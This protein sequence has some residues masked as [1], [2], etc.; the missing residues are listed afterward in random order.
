M[1]EIESYIYKQLAEKKISKAD[2]KKMLLEIKKSDKKVYKD[3]AII[4]VACKLPKAEN[5]KMF[6]NSLVKEKNC[7]DVF[8]KER[9][10]QWIEASLN[11]TLSEL[12]TGTAIP[13]GTTEKDVMDSR[14]VGGFLDDISSF[15]NGFFGISPKE[16]KFMNPEQR[17][18][19]ETAWEAV[20]DA[21][22]GGDKFYGTRTGVFIGKD[23]TNLGLYKYLTEADTMHVTG[24]W[25]G[26]LASRISYLYNLKGPSLVIDTACSSGLVSLHSASKSISNGECEMALVGGIQLQYMSSKSNSYL[27]L[28]M[29]ESGDNI[30]R[31]FDKKANGTVWS[32]GV[33][34]LLIKDL[35]QAIK[36]GDNIQAVIK[37]SAINNDGASN[38]ITAPDAQAQEDVIVRA[39][40]EGN[41]NPETISYFEAHGT[42]TILG[43]P[44]EIKG[45]TNAFK[46]FT[47]KKQ[48]CAIG[49]TKANIGHTVATSGLA[50]VIKIIYAMKNKI[51][52]PSINFMEPN[53]YIN[54]IGS[55][56]YLNDT[57]QKW[58]DSNGALRACIN[59][60]GFSGT[61]CHLVLE[62]PPEIK[63]SPRTKDKNIFLLSAKN[64][65]S[66]MDLVER[67]IYFLESDIITTIEDICYTANTGRGHY[68]YRIAIICND[69]LE[70]KNKLKELKY[71]LEINKESRTGQAF[72]GYHKTVN[73]KT[74]L[75]VGEITEKYKFELSKKV[76][77]IT[78]KNDN[79]LEKICK[80]YV[81]GADIQFEKYYVEEG[82]RRVSL[83]TYA[84]EKKYCW[85]SK[86]VF[87]NKANETSSNI[88]HPL[89]DKLLTDSIDSIIYQ[90]NF[91]A[92][93]YWVVEEHK[94][95]NSYLVPGITYIEMARE[96]CS[97][98]FNTEHIQ[99]HNL[100][101]LAPLTVQENEEVSVQTILE[102]R[103]VEVEFSIC[104]K[105]NK[106]GWCVHAKGKATKIEDFKYKTYDIQEAKKACNLLVLD[107]V[108]GYFNK[109]A[110]GTDEE[111]TSKH[112]QFGG[113][114][115]NYIKTESDPTCNKELLVTMY[116]PD[117]YDDDINHYYL[118]PALLDNA[119]NSGIYCFKGVYLPFSYKSMKIYNRIP[120]EFFSH[121]V[122][123]NI[124]DKELETVKFDITLFDK[125]G[126]VIAEVED[127]SIKR[128]GLSDQIKF[129]D[130][131]HSG[132]AYCEK[133]WIKNDLINSSELIAKEGIVLFK[134][135]SRLGE[136]IS[137]LFKKDGINVIEVEKSNEYRKIGPYK[138]TIGNSEKDYT[139]LVEDLKNHN[140]KQII[141]CFSNDNLAN[142]KS[143][144]EKLNNGVYSLFYLAKSLVKNRINYKVDMYVVTRHSDIIIAEDYVVCPEN[145]AMIGIAKVIPEEYTNYSCKCIDIDENSDIEKLIFEIKMNSS[146]RIIAY[147]NNERY[148]EEFRK[149]SLNDLKET[150]IKIKDNGTYIITGGTG[151]LG[152]EASRFFTEQ[153]KVN[154]VLLNRSKFPE[155]DQWENIVSEDNNKKL[156]QRINVI[157][158]IER[159]GSKVVTYSVDISNK[160]ELGK[161]INTIRRDFGQIDGIVHAA[162]VAGDGF[163][164]NKDINVFNE[165]IKPKIYGTVA[166]DELTENDNLDFFINFSS[167][168]T[169]QGLPGQS[170]YI[171]ANSFLDS[172]TKLRNMK[173][174]KTVCINWPAWKEVGMAFDYG[175]VNDDNIFK[176]IETEKAI[177]ILDESIKS[178]FTNIIPVEINYPILVKV[179][180]KLSIAISDDLLDETKKEERANE[181]TIFEKKKKSLD[182]IVIKGKAEEFTDIEKNIALL[183]CEILDFDEIDIYD[184][185][186]SVGG[187]SILA[188]QL[189][190]DINEI[191]SG[192]I[193]I[194]D[195]FT[196]S[197]IDSLS[198]YIERKLA[199]GNL[200]VNKEIKTNN[201]FKK[202]E[203][204]NMLEEFEDGT[205]S[206][207]EVLMKLGDK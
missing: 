144:E 60:F 22:Y 75:D 13:D 186:N 109:E 86:K 115:L 9:A 10:E 12:M 193:D 177:T 120:K 157:K 94:L 171:T 125:S 131:Y 138:Y 139:L 158:E 61:N 65:N 198:K 201:N 81:N 93:K 52:P 161:V 8:P 84:F 64:K 118:H 185:F 200:M 172:F 168:V 1:K 134:D 43:D 203:I 49:S 90:T 164:I 122:R 27:N 156:I 55:P 184:N 30:I 50:G 169:I 136:D 73:N 20:E 67:Y 133:G 154:L 15:D 76:N 41:I 174:K 71:A 24:S 14:D 25:S 74:V 108:N 57:L 132:V 204:D 51:L 16:A 95:M 166:L 189:Y 42:G 153:A 165:V 70:L 97:K 96:V 124:E 121:I 182:K 155:R 162:G 2:A 38:G 116:L 68:S 88:G 149:Y 99:L 45:L 4:G 107:K 137:S 77:E 170:D 188:S 159:L 127:Y 62:S 58:D 5:A 128:M 114:W 163:I 119:I 23:N 48:F 7:L 53:P 56:V 160:N 146:D 183:W 167:I 37:S 72:Y 123:K 87:T 80:L 32:E 195:I 152:L 34:T 151:G 6:W 148:T 18:I 66:L 126:N 29:V 110:L 11:N 197:T 202:S 143:I 31:T 113:R 141:H 178:N 36:D 59:S 79:D 69:K 82:Y 111:P 91:S 192:I 17:L 130:N 103:N 180:E 117:E 135:E 145:N 28:D 92:K 89:F 175:L 190:N 106:G 33:A 191:Y 104:S 196:Y 140:L 150:N 40:T 179:K 187:D 147:R 54:F 173:G 101:F 176:P 39:W 207:E 44:I 98:Y 129:K 194:T 105:D 205:V 100:T 102:K 78:S 206:M 19:L 199:D 21:G 46:R 26:I 85:A 63:K 142:D 112:F 3:M 47:D 83:P 181:Y 35:E